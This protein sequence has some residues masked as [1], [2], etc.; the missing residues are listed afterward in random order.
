M[1]YFTLRE[2]EIR[3]DNLKKQP[4]NVSVRVER[5]ECDFFF[6]TQGIVPC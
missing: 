5:K 4:R 2:G 1:I 6:F 3:R